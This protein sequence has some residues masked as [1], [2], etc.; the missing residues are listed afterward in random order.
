VQLSLRVLFCID[1]KVTARR[2]L[3]IYIYLE[4]R[5]FESRQGLGIF[6]TNMSRP[7]LGP[8]KPPIQRTT[9]ALSLEKMPPGSEADHS[10]SSSAEVKNAWSYTS[11][12]QYDFIAWYSVKK[13]TRT[14]L[15]LPLPLPLYMT[16]IMNKKPQ[17]N[18]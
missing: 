1:G 11:V 13:S 12:P 7:V 14:T 17:L 2:P 10:N 4:D 18:V 8:T 16:A 5:E 9:G 3:D 6:L 15:P